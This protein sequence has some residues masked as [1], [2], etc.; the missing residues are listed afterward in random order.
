[1]GVAFEVSSSSLAESRSFLSVSTGP[2]T[3]VRNFELC[4]L[5]LSERRLLAIAQEACAT[6]NLGLVVKV[7]WD[8]VF[9]GLIHAIVR[10][11]DSMGM[12][13]SQDSLSIEFG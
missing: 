10:D 12:R 11:V 5:V 6:V 8:L 1:M 9:A 2:K 4:F 13:L 7:T 3:S